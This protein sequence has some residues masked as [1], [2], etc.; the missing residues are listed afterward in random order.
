MSNV[1]TL[2]CELTHTHTYTHT[3]H[4][5]KCGHTPASCQELC[6]LGTTLS[7]LLTILVAASE[8][9]SVAGPI[10]MIAN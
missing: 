8:S 10:D 2:S 4:L 3:T 6:C 5:L 1:F 7:L 9:P